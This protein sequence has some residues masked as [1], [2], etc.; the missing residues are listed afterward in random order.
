[1]RVYLFPTCLVATF[2]PRVV[3]AAQRVLTR[4]GA[5]VEL[6]REATCCGQP[7]Y[8]AGLQKAAC[9]V[10]RE[11]VRWMQKCDGPIVFLGG[12]CAAMVR[13][14][15]PS[16]LAETPEAEAAREVAG[17]VW[18][19]SAFLVRYMGIERVPGCFPYT[20]AY[21]PSCH[22]LRVLGVDKEPRHL[23]DG[24]EGLRRVPWPD[25][26]TCCGFGGVFSGWMPEVAQAMGNAKITALFQS[27]AQI[28]VTC[29]PGCLLHLRGLAQNRVPVW[30]L[31]E[32]LDYAMQAREAV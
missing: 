4:L 18:E 2:L 8:N 30:H 19:F 32:V 28:G 6:L 21:H 9:R 16:L 1:M 14:A 23:L 27:R 22:M 15:Y 3:E 17:R 24:L 20:V 25:E 7:M 31:A 12:S 13:H 5:S 29:D 10:A 11:G 26:D